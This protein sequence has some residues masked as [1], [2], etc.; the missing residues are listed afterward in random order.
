LVIGS[1]IGGGM[2]WQ[3]RVYKPHEA[4]GFLEKFFIKLFHL[5]GNLNPTDGGW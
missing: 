3:M 5:G 1:D 2:D 4:K